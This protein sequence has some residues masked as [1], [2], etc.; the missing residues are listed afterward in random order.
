MWGGALTELLDTLVDL[1]AFSD[2]KIT[3]RNNV[4]KV[5]RDDRLIVTITCH[6]K[7]YDVN[8]IAAMRD[9]VAAQLVKDAFNESEP[10][11]DAA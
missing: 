7:W 10:R 1:R 5:M 2:A 6:E 11:P 9:S 8:G 4:Y 3:R